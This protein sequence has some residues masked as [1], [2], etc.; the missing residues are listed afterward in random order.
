[1][2]YILYLNSKEVDMA[3]MSE[4]KLTKQVNDIANLSTRQTNFSKQLKIRR[5]AVNEEILEYLGTVGSE[6]DIP[7]RKIDADLLNAD[8]GDFVIYKGWAVILSRDEDFYTIA[9]YDGVIDWYKAMDNVPM[10]SLDL[11]EIDHFRTIPTIQNS[12]LNTLPYKY[13][14]ADF[15]GAATKIGYPNINADYLI[16]SVNVEW[17]WNQIFE[18]LGFTFS[19][20]VFA[21][22]D[23]KDLWLTYPKGTTVGLDV[24]VPLLDVT[25]SHNLNYNPGPLVRIDLDAFLLTAGSIL[26]D[27]NGIEYYVCPSDGQIRVSHTQAISATY[28]DGGQGQ[29]LNMITLN[30]RLAVENRN[31]NTIYLIN[32]G[33]QLYIPVNE[34]DEIY[35]Y[36]APTYQSNFGGWPDYVFGEAKF[37]LDLYQGEKIDFK[38]A[39]DKLLI[40]DFINE[41]LWILCLTPFKDPYSKNI[42]F[43]TFEERVMGMDAIDMSDKFVKLK[44]E[45][46]KYSNYA[47]LNYLRHKYNAS[48]ANYNDGAFVIQD[49][50]LKDATTVI[51][52]KFFTPEFEKEVDIDGGRLLRTYKLWNKESNDGVGNPTKY[53]ALDNRFYFIKYKDVTLTNPL[54]IESESLGDSAIFS[55]L[56]LEDYT[57]L[58]FKEIQK[59][60]YSKLGYVLNKVK[61]DVLQFMLNRQDYVELDFTKKLYV[62]QLG[63]SFLLN[64]ISDFE[65]NKVTDLEVL[66]I[67]QSDLI[68]GDDGGGGGDP[69]DPV[70]L[71]FDLTLNS[72]VPT[73]YNLDITSELYLGVNLGPGET[74]S[75]IEVQGYSGNLY[76]DQ[77]GDDLAQGLGVLQFGNNFILHSL[78]IDN[79]YDYLITPR[80][81][82]LVYHV[83]MDNSISGTSYHKYTIIKNITIN[84]SEAW[85]GQFFFNV[86]N[87]G[88]DTKIM[89]EDFKQNAPLRPNE[90]YSHIVP[91]DF[92][93]E[94]GTTSEF[95]ASQNGPFTLGINSYFADW[96]FIEPH[97]VDFSYFP[98]PGTVV[99]L[100]F[101]FE[102]WAYDTVAMTYR[103]VKDFIGFQVTLTYNN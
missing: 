78:N 15:N 92:V 94:P 87:A 7:Y 68:S 91:L 44:N 49:E 35:F 76:A 65:P 30:T 77:F 72:V 5:T 56:P 66:K 20:D 2:S 100:E 26:L 3:G 32:Q 81:L 59:K 97:K 63:A 53:K 48:N 47:K 31:S 19:G 71:T 10:S 4:I 67:S 21:T 16:P 54:T 70:T 85:G 9:I 36:A 80:T 55:S 58:T 62:E 25:S 22:P 93:Y 102:L 96:L 64:K 86:T 43:K 83:I 39:F 34:G 50:N 60:A 17:L 40:K 29:E 33:Q 51:Q 42:L 90:I 38:G 88:Q 28:I 84:Y 12:I 46:Y 27:T 103:L 18:Y 79:T 14:I 98:S 74:I 73:D 82:T 95:W 52:S 101:Y 8:S 99:G 13:I 11:S 37:V 23:F 69:N 6:T 89:T 75:Q 57:G 24:T 61:L 41:V 1:M 45:K